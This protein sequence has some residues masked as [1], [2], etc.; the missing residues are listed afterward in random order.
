M[1]CDGQPTGQKTREVNSRGI[2]CGEGQVKIL[3]EK[4]VMRKVKFYGE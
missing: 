3:S 1:G 2:V 4:D